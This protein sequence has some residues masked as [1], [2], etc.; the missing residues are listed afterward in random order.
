MASS[1]KK[2]VF[3]YPIRIRYR[4]PYDYDG[5]IELIR[6]YFGEVAIDTRKEPKFKYKT[7]G[8]GAE[9]EFKFTGDRKITHYIKFYLTVT[10]HF[11]NVKRK[12]VV[13]DGE[14]RRGTDGK[15][16]ITIVGE[17]ELDYADS[18]DKN[19]KLD[20]WM[21]EVLDADGTGLQFEDNKATGKKY[22]QKVLLTLDSKIK[23]FL[24][25]ECV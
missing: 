23:S 12:E 17:V 9:A 16:E 24:K 14:K 7:G 1:G 19:K 20:K 5:L 11:Y 21:Q 8:G 13:I 2:G 4:G 25:M 6:N 15:L 10:G 18:F 3:E 22:V